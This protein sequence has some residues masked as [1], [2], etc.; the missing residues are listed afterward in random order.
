M[1]GTDLARARPKSA[2]W[3]CKKKYYNKIKSVILLLV[4]QYH[5]IVEVIQFFPTIK[6]IVENKI[7][8]LV[9]IKLFFQLPLI[10]LYH[11][12]EGFVA[13]DPY[14]KFVWNGN[15]TILGSI[16][17]EKSVNEKI[18]NCV[19]MKYF[20]N[21]NIMNIKSEMNFT[22]TLFMASIPPQSSIYCF[23]SLSRYS[24]TR[25][26]DFSVWTISCNVT[27]NY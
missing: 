6:S 9:D 24:K 5:K 3:N 21:N 17:T 25:V 4:S 14:V 13:L 19:L 15:R 7:F 1:V 8:Q 22:L 2:N 20:W 12:W 10:L 26:N 18:I 27:A 23:R 16:E 11:L